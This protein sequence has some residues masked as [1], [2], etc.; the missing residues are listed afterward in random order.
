[1]SRCGGLPACVCV[2]ACVCMC[3]V[4]QANKNHGLEV[5][6]FCC[7]GPS[8]P[9]MHTELL[10]QAFC[11][12][13][14]PATLLQFFSPFCGT[15]F[16][17]PAFVSVS[18]KARKKET[19]HTHTHTHTHTPKKQHE[20]QQESGQPSQVH[21]TA[22]V[23]ELTA[24]STLAGESS[25][26]SANNDITD[27]KMASTPRIGRQRSSA[28]SWLSHGASATVVNTTQRPGHQLSTR[29]Q[30]KNSPFR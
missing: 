23:V 14:R 24:A 2:C 27:I 20:N 13:R 22:L 29:P 28:L 26:G 11:P 16:C 10:L 17:L 25:F 12:S 1:M 9:R 30:T 7:G 15:P 21:T 8:S 3:M 5:E 18:R 19:I 6:L 4:D